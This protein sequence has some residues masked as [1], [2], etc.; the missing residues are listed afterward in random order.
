MGDLNEK[1]ETGRENEERDWKR[2]KELSVF[3]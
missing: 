2:E 3:K 1:K